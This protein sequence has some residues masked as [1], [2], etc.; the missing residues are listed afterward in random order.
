VENIRE[1]SAKLR[2]LREILRDIES[3]LVAYSGGVDSTFLL[4]I[5]AE[6]LGEKALG[7]TIRSV[8][9]P[10]REFERASRLAAEF[11]A[12]HEV[13]EA[14][15]LRNPHVAAN[16]RDRCYHCKKGIFTEL[17]ALA[18]KRGLAAV[19]DGT[20]TDDHSDYRP[21][22]R[23]LHELGVRSPLSEAG[24]CKKDIRELS[25]QVGLET[26]NLAPAAC[27]ASRVPYD[28]PLTLRK[29][30][31]IEK[32]EDALH[33]LGLSQLRVRCHEDVARIE[34]PLAEFATVLESREAVLGDVKGAGFR[35]VT[36][37]LTG[38]QMG[39]LNPGA[40]DQ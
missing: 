6:E 29:L 7:V 32:A 20:N 37:D 18:E 21:G 28:S 11:G 2:E 26:W 34:I 14:D 17:V 36:L 13:M 39:S 8:L 3:V 33:D 16:P 38:Y 1:P 40:T 30:E 25:R 22:H 15:V 23:A 27:L 9:V 35:Y 5:A 4:K 24:M 12:R 31:M 19:C 10:E